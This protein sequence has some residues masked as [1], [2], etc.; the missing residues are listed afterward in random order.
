M[1]QQDKEQCMAIQDHLNGDVTIDT[2]AYS[3]TSLVAHRRKDEFLANGWTI[4][5][6][7][8]NSDLTLM[9]KAK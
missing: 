9:G 1:P 3:E 6:E 5:K 4:I 2:S 8:A 7:S